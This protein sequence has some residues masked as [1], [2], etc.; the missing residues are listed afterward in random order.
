VIDRVEE[1]DTSFNALDTSKTQEFTMVNN[2][3]TNV[4]N[5]TSSPVSGIVSSSSFDADWDGDFSDKLPFGLRAMN[6]VSVCPKGA[7]QQ[8]GGATNYSL[9]YALVEQGSGLNQIKLR[10]PNAVNGNVICTVRADS[11][12]AV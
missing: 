12:D 5:P 1:V 9:P 7:V 4:T 2:S 3:F 8:S 10:W 6:V 11:I